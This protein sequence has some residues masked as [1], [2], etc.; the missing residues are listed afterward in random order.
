MQRGAAGLLA[1]LAV[2]PDLPTALQWFVDGAVRWSPLTAAQADWDA[3]CRD[4]EGAAS[5]STPAS[6]VFGVCVRCKSTRVTVMN[7]QLRQT[8]SPLAE[9]GI[10]GPGRTRA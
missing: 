1:L 3:Y 6:S 2:A 7:K 8:G 10:P 4:V 9:R 5:G